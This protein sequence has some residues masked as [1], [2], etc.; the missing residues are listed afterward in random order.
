V[1]QTVMVV[2]RDPITAVRPAP[3][4]EEAAAIAAALERF[5]H[6]TQQSAPA[7]GALASGW[8]AAA[9]LEAVR[10]EGPPPAGWNS[11]RPNR[12]AEISPVG[13]GTS[14]VIRGPLA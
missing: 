11:A 4:L 3:S 1:R 6:D 9:R 2:E 14:P 5:R 7:H 13:A 12:W 8:I 10:W